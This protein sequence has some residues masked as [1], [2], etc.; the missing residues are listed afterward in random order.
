METVAGT[1]PDEAPK[2][3]PGLQLVATE[4]VL[5]SKAMEPALS[6]GIL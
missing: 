3:P 4:S 1:S 5:V 2:S 6:P